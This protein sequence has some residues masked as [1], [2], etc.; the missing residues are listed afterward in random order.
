[1]E[2][3]A[4]TSPEIK[5][6]AGDYL[7]GLNDSQLQA[8]RT[9]DGPVLVVAGAGTGKTRVIVSRLAYLV[10]ERNIA[11]DKLLAIT[12]TA[13]AA[14]EM[15]ERVQALC[16]GSDLS[17]MWIGTI[18]ALGFEI[19]QH[20]GTAIGVH[21]PGIISKPDRA[22][23]IRRLVRE[24]QQDGCTITLREAERSIAQDR[25]GLSAPGRMSPACRRYE[26]LLRETGMFDF[27]DLITKPL[28]VF[29]ESPAALELVRGRFSHVSVDEFQDVSPA[30]YALIKTICPPPFNL[31]AVGDADQA[32]YAFRGARVEHFLGFA[33]DF[34]QAATVYLRR[35]YRSSETILKAAD[36]VIQKNTHRLERTLVPLEPGGA[37]VEVVST[38]TE[39]AE[40]DFIA[41]E[42]E[43]LLGGTR[44]E[45]MGPSEDPAAGF[46]DIAVL[47]R[48]HRQGRII[49]RTLGQRGIPLATVSSC[50]IYEEPEIKT[51]VDFLHVLAEPENTAALFEL[52]CT[53]PFS[54]GEA[55][56]R[57][58]REHA[59]R[60][61]KPLLALLRDGLFPADIRGR[62]IDVLQNLSD[63]IADLAVQSREA[64]LDVLIENIR[65]I[66]CGECDSESESLLDLLTASRAFAG[67]PAAESI[68]LFLERIAFQQE[69]DEFAPAGEAVRLMTVHAAKGLEFQTVFIAGLEEDLFPYRPENGSCDEE[70]ERRL[71]YVALTRARKKIY[72]LNAE[73]RFLFGTH[74]RKKPSCFTA[75]IPRELCTRREVQ[76]HRRKK[77][78]KQQQMSLFDM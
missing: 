36:A 54:P 6:P 40:A 10:R 9:A 18:H 22:G 42:I 31:C 21:K 26:S 55:A 48:L 32:I 5:N 75:D 11:P 24:L 33:R 56:A 60:V 46:A 43:R 64:P 38:A 68:P 16:R 59:C 67:L 45:T 37:P 71:F 76:P 57:K 61:G 73:S 28:E 29:R 35:N 52:L 20:Y 8:V 50:S 13:K 63:C 39:Q 12:F 47:Y 69:G 30:Q 15:R 34:P 53:A 66:A 4:G 62:G 44:F 78:K 58:L 23:L 49:G 65:T 17:G 2:S 3:G 51:V 41:R 77:K 19:L 25:N 72:L 14:A 7:T 70:E 74:L 27:D 1:M